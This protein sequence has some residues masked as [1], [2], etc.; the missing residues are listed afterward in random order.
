MEVMSMVRPLYLIET[1]YF[2]IGADKVEYQAAD[3]GDLPTICTSLSRAE[4]LAR[5]SVNFYC[6]TFG[7]TIL[8]EEGNRRAVSLNKFHRW[9]LV[10]NGGEERCTFTIYLHYITK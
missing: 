8:K 6:E 2:F 9:T 3:G 5:W 7:F 4:E 1:K 10:R